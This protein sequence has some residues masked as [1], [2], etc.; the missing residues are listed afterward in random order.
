MRRNIILLVVGASIFACNDQPSPVGPSGRRL[1][2]ALRSTDLYNG[3]D[4]Q[5]AINSAGS[6]TTLWLHGTINV[7][8]Q[9]VI[10]NKTGLYIRGDGPGQTTINFQNGDGS[11]FG[12]HIEGGITTLDIAHMSIR[13]TDSVQAIGMNEDPTAVVSGM[14]FTDL[15]IR[16]VKGGISVYGEAGRRSGGGSCDGVTMYTNYLENILGSGSGQGY[17]LHNSGCTNVRYTENEIRNAGR[18]SIYQAYSRGPVTIDHNLIINH[19]CGT[20]VSGHA[21]NGPI[22]HN[23]VALVVARSENVVVAHNLILN[24]H[25]GGALSAEYDDTTHLSTKRIR[26]IHNTV[27]LPGSYDLLINTLAA[28]TVQVWGN[29]FVH[30]GDTGPSAMVIDPNYSG[31][32]IASP[33]ARWANTKAL[34]AVKDGNTHNAYPYTFVMQGPS[35]SAYL[36]EVNT[37]YNQNFDDPSYW[38]YTGYDNTDFAGFSAMVS[39]I[40][41]AYVMKAGTLQRLTPNRT[42]GGSAWTRSTSPNTWSSFQGMG[43]TTNSSDADPGLLFVLAGSA[44]YQVDPT[45]W[46]RTQGSTNWAGAQAVAGFDS[47][48]YIM[49]N[50]VVHRIKSTVGVGADYEDYWY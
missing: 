38:T 48:A 28:D 45:T 39:G 5:G 35:T 34:D 9:L 24:P 12:F 32:T 13:G 4:I 11:N 1:P 7:N 27:L 37:S 26:F 31:Y 8:T 23:S 44:L 40:G 15:D 18:H 16:N 25:G 29:V 3:D 20:L 10:T 17:G 21:C 30:S 50:N 6:N 14:T 22:D 2:Q 19:R 41:Y 36:H 47:H 46:S 42:G 33:S 49:Q 43:W